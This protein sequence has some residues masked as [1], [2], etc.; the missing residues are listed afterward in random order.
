MKKRNLGIYALI[1]V[2]ASAIT[3]VTSGTAE[4][5]MDLV[6]NSAH[7]CKQE[8]IFRLATIFYDAK[9]D[10]I[11]ERTAGTGV[12]VDGVLIKDGAITVGTPPAAAGNLVK[13]DAAGKYYDGGAAASIRAL[14]IVA[15]SYDG[16]DI[17]GA[18]YVCNGTDDHLVF[19]QA[20]DAATNGTTL[21]VMPGTYRFYTSNDTE[22]KV[23]KQLDIIGSKDSTEI[24]RYNL[25]KRSIYFDAGSHYHELKYIKFTQDGTASNGI[26]TVLE[27]DGY[28]GRIED[29]YFDGGDVQLHIGPQT[30][31]EKCRFFNAS[32][33]YGVGVDCAGNYSCIRNCYWES[34][35]KAIQGEGRGIN[36]YGNYI[37]GNNYGIILELVG[38]N[39]IDMVIENNNFRVCYDSIVLISGD[40]YKF[41]NT[42][43]DGNAFQYN[44]LPGG[45]RY[46]INLKGAVNTVVCNNTFE[47]S[48][49]TFIRLENNGSS[50][51][52]SGTKIMGN[53]GE[54]STHVYAVQEV[55][56]SQDYTTLLGNTWTA[57][58]SGTV[59]LLGSHSIDK[60]T[61][62]NNAAPLASPTFTGTVGGISATMVGLGSVTN[63]AQLTIANNLSDLN[64]AATA[65]SNIGL[66]VDGI[67]V[68]FD[69]GGFAL[70]A[71]SYIDV[72]VRFACTISGYT[73]YNNIRTAAADTIEMSLWRCTTAQYDS[74][75]THPV[76]GDNIAASAPISIPITTN[77]Y[78][79]DTALPGWTKTLAAGDVL[80]LRVTSCVNMSQVTII[81]NTTR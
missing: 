28:Y 17:T 26:Q 61:V 57:G 9:T 35:N 37:N 55:D 50:A 3:F 64:N 7:E 67:L 24:I 43:I 1:L 75:A 51:N 69:G 19:Q 6:I 34:C 71:G 73:A 81:L 59:S 66:S 53:I 60:D 10:G 22:F 65:R 33:V 47:G 12:T 15:T 8:V 68:S 52:C 72:P 14:K 23:T 41:T 77:Y 18:D 63:N 39:D 32:G 54:G 46:C 74:G 49:N 21:K 44:S 36:I 62:I 27:G 38:P 56:A 70:V 4:T 16:G 76:A 29:C 79:T 30:I 48:M 2:L 11:S 31:V 80:R 42:L 13:M 58:S 20:N 5:V 40:T 78:R 25:A 45:Q